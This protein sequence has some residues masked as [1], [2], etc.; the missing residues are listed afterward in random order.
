M[1]LQRRA[2]RALQEASAVKLRDYQ[3]NILSQVATAT[4]NDLVQLD[5]GAGKTPVEAA[6]AKGAER[7]IVLAH[8]NLL[9]SQISEKLAAA[10]VFHGVIGTEHTRRRCMIDQRRGGYQNHVIADEGAT[11]FAASVQSVLARHHRHRL[12]ADPSLPWLLIVDEAHHAIKDN[13]WGKLAEIFQNARIVGF[14]ATPARADGQSLSIEKEGLFERLVQADTLKNDSV[15]TLIE[16]GCLSPFRVWSIPS[17]IDD[18]A[19]RIG[20]NGDYTVPS[21]EVALS[22]SQIVGDAVTEYRRLADGKRAVAMCV[23]IKNAEKAAEEFRAAGIPAAHISSK[24][25]AIEIAR[26][27]DAFR[28]REIL[29]LCNVD[30]VGEGFDLPGIEA[31]IMLRK[32]ASLTAYRQWIGRALRPMEGKSY[33]VI[34]DH[35]G[36]VV[37]HGLPDDHI[38]WSL[39]FPASPRFLVPRCPCSE[40]RIWYEAWRA[41]CPNCGAQNLLLLKGTPPGDYYLSIE[42]LSGE[43]IESA[44]RQAA[45]NAEQDKLQRE[46]VLPAAAGCWVQSGT[47][48][49]LCRDLANRMVEYLDGVEDPSMVNVFFRD[50]TVQ[51]QQFWI[52]QFTIHDLRAERSKKFIRVFKKW[53]QSHLSKRTAP[54]KAAKLT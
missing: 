47:V 1:G 31:L 20:A 10:G 52:A 12:P 8:R 13:M 42:K 49:L 33:A 37:R 5:T 48:G 40:C 24:M 43:L 21:L 3:A 54:R 17:Y 11:V 4:T 2:A 18:L 35:V 30:M 29:V 41:S 28:A 39:D 22:K 51:S 6:L 44:R 23:S 16:K 34:I 7:C 32:T 53:Q 26:R 14:T 9:I 27:V 19:L 36:N 50:N 46:V 25:G 15:Q 45:R 38:A